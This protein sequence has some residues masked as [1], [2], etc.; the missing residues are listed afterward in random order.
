MKIGVIGTGTMG[1]LIIEALIKSK[2]VKPSHIWMTNRTEEKARNLANAYPGLTVCPTPHEV[3]K[4]AAI[5]FLCIKPLQFFPLL[6]SV[7]NTWRPDQLAVSI[8]SPIT[9]TQL[10]KMISCS[11]T[12]VVPSIVNQALAGSTLVTFGTSMNDRQKTKIWTLLENFSH[13]V[14]ISEKNIRV[15]SDLS[16]CGPAFLS[17]L[18]EKMIEGA[19]R[20][21]PISEDDATELVTQMV[22]G[23][24]KLL[25]DQ[26]F[27]LTELREKVT[28]KGGVTGVG[29]NVLK[30]GY[31]GVFEHLFEETRKKFIED[32]QAVDPF[33]DQGDLP[34]ESR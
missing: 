20:S 24:G 29:L 18:L 16:S 4:H 27:T 2:S 32:H 8:T 26:T 15:A 13:P 23:F 3:I 6:Q 25:E 1:S 34:E 21:T 30:T 7:Q 14:E 28:V 11:V 10:E 19:V 22:I 5:V 12:R 9:L 33:F 17:F 31:G